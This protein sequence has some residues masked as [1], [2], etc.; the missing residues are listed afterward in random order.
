MAYST[1]RAR[2]THKLNFKSGRP[3][4]VEKEQNNRTALAECEPTFIDGA[5]IEA[6]KIF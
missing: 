5:I 6:P 1:D 4:L 2:A 3:P